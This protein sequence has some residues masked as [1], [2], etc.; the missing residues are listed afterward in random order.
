MNGE[1]HLDVIYR[2]RGR[3]ITYY[4]EDILLL[5]AE[6]E[7]SLFDSRATNNLKVIASQEIIETP[8]KHDRD[9]YHIHYTNDIYTGAF[10][11]ETRRRIVPKGQHRF[12]Q[13]AYRHAVSI[14]GGRLDSVITD[15][16]K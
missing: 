4:I 9:D 16:R 15:Y 5:M 8:K 1:D 13:T 2:L 6:L 14:G 11:V 12:W 3:D 7:P 10:Y